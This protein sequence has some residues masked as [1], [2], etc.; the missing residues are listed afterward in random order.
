MPPEP[1]DKQPLLEAALNGAKQVLSKEDD[2]NK[3]LED[4]SLIFS[5]A[6]NYIHPFEDGNG[7]TSRIVGFL[8][9]EGYDGSTSLRSS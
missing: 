6:I 5:G 9:K 7:R 8:T 3:G 1:E 2:P 4:A